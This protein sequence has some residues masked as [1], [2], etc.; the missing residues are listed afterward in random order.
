MIGILVQ[1][2]VKMLAFT[3]PFLFLVKLVSNVLHVDLS[4]EVSRGCPRD[5]SCTVFMVSLLAM[6]CHLLA[7][8]VTNRSLRIH[9]FF[10]LCLIHHH[11]K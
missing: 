7:F 2:M 3:F 4:V 1:G 9:L 6:V 8:W 10:C 5:M 11:Y